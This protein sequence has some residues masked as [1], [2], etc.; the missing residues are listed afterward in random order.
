MQRVDKKIVYSLVSSAI[1]MAVAEYDIENGISKRIKRPNIFKIRWLI[2]KAK[3]VI[4]TGKSPM[5]VLEL[6]DKTIG[7][8]EKEYPREGVIKQL[9]LYI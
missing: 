5:I 1:G 2:N 4:M 3:T 8:L 9:L 7:D 6:H